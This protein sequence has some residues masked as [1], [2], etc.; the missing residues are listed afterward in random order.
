MQKF[1]FIAFYAKGGRLWDPKSKMKTMN[2]SVGMNSYC[3]HTL[4]TILMRSTVHAA[5]K[6]CRL[7]AQ[8]AKNHVL[9]TVK[10]LQSSWLLNIWLC[11]H[12]LSLSL[13]RWLSASIY[14][15]RY[16]NT[17]QYYCGLCIITIMNALKLA[18]MVAALLVCHNNNRE[19]FWVDEKTEIGTY[20]VHTHTLIEIDRYDR[21]DREWEENALVFVF[22]LYVSFICSPCYGM[23]VTPQ[24]S[25]YHIFNTYI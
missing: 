20:S 25:L 18:F 23:Y 3:V 24:A 7:C 14:P 17:I 13:T 4:Q 10:I 16:R 19:P 9:F 8:K 1:P 15:V 21:Y 11:S 12:S 6:E 5:F 2:G 22:Y